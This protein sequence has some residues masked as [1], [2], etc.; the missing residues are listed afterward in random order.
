MPKHL[1]QASVFAVLLTTISTST[2]FACSQGGQCTGLGACNFTQYLYNIEFD[3]GCAWSY[4]GATSV[5]TSGGTKMCNVFP[6]YLQLNAGAQTFA[7][8]FVTIPSSQ[9]GTHW[10]LGFNLEAEPS[11]STRGADTMFVKVYDV[12]TATDLVVSPTHTATSSPSCNLF[13]SSF[14]G[15][16][17][18]HQLEVIVVANVIHSDAH[19]YVTGVQLDGAP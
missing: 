9:T 11:A 10:T 7:A 13:T 14:T 15:D 17:H 4:S 5:T 6:S 18:G 8:Q 2:A 16:L 1:L 3:E 19:F 12:T